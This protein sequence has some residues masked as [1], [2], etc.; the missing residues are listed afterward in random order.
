MRSEAENSS[1][2]E[3]QAEAQKPRPSILRVIKHG[4]RVS[5]SPRSRRWRP[6]QGHVDI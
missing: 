6:T 3:R 1:L 2:N 5:A 4:Q